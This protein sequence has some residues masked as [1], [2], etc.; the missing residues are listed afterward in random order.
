MVADGGAEPHR[1][2]VVLVV[3]DERERADRYADWVAERWSVVTATDVGE[4][5][6]AVDDAPVVALVGRRLADRDRLL[7]CLDERAG[8][9]RAA[10]VSASDPELVPDEFDDAL[11]DPARGTVLDAVEVL[12]L[13]VRHDELLAEY[14]A[15]AAERAGPEHDPDG[16]GEL[17]GRLSDVRASIDEILAELAAREVDLYDAL[18]GGPPDDP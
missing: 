7:D 15:L 11:V 9:Y 10:M 12:S 6:E 13:L 2:P 8:N 4:A 1:E 14:Y 3:A 17:G 16:Y 5:V 18:S